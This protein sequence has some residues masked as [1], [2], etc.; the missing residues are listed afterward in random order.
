M[1]GDLYAHNTLIDNQGNTILGDFGAATM[2]DF[3]NIDGRKYEMLDVRAFGY[4][5][6]DLIINLVKNDSE[7]MR[8][9][10]LKQIRNKCLNKET[11]NRPS[12]SDI[13]IDLTTI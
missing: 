11:L 10:T 13:L 5:I 1:H 6:D 3:K 7:L 2:Y 8:L 9:N 12:F 4:L